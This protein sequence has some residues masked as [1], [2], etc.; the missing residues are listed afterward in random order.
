MRMEAASIT[1]HCQSLRLGAVGA[2]FAALT[3]EAR[4]GNHSHLR[5]NYLR[6]SS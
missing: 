5:A 2:Q 1:Q 6:M 4:Q 3:E